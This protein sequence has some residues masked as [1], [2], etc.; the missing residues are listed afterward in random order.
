M[1]KER[2]REGKQRKR[3]GAVTDKREERWGD[4]QE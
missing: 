4:R 2:E 3:G 1:E